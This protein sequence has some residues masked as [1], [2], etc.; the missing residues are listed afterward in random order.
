M[1]GLVRTLAAALFVIPLFVAAADAIDINTADKQQ[2]MQLNGVGEARA[3]AIIDYRDEHGEF[4][5]VDELGEV[6][7]IGPAT[8]DNNRDMLTAGAND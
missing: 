7:G 6:S 4:A 2:F 1:K 5:S 3:E 8:L